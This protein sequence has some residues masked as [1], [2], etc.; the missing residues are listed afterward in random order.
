MMSENALARQR[1]TS[2]IYTIIRC[3]FPLDLW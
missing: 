2:R 3:Q 1:G